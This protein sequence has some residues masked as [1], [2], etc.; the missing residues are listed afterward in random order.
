[1][2]SANVHRII[3]HVLACGS[4]FRY[5]SR[6]R[7]DSRMGDY[8]E[9]AELPGNILFNCHA[10]P[11]WPLSPRSDTPLTELQTPIPASL[12]KPA[13]NRGY[14]CCGVGDKEERNEEPERE[15][16]CLGASEEKIVMRELMDLCGTFGA[17]SAIVVG[18]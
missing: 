13:L 6:S 18:A 10:T 1:M 3:G 9:S 2:L 16:P 11:S 7:I 14:F 5:P 8:A 4:G 15:S 12:T 17:S